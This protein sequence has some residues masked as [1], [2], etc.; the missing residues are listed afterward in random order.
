MLGPCEVCGEEGVYEVCDV[1][2]SGPWVTVCGV[3]CEDKVMQHADD[4][5]CTTCEEDRS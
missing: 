4:C 3:Q 1:N 2:A 5:D